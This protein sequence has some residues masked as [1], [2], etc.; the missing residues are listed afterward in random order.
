MHL[1][2]SQISTRGKSAFL[3]KRYICTGNIKPRLVMELFDQMIKNPI[4]C[5]AQ[6]FG[7]LV[8]YPNEN[9]A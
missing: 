2:I 3:F 5:Y 6:K 9:F 7:V 8:I 1:V 4:L